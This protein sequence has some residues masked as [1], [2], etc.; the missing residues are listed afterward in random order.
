[1]GSINIIK[2]MSRIEILGVA[3]VVCMK[4]LVLANGGIFFRDFV[5][6]YI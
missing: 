3:L 5:F 4:E 2:N 1:M 6:V